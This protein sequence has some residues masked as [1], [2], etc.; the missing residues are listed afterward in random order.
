MKNFC[1]LHTH[2]VFSD[3]TYTPTELVRAASKLGL[4][5]IALT[6]HNTIAGLPEFLKA[7]EELGMEAVP[8]VEFSTEYEGLDVHI[9]GLF[10]EPDDYREVSELLEEGCRQKEQS[11]IALVN[12]LN[13]DGYVLNYDAIKAQSPKGQINR[14]HIAAALTEKGYTCSIKDAFDTLLSPKRGYYNPPRR[15]DVFEIIRFIKSLGAVAVLA[16]PLLTM[17][18]SMLRRFLPEARKHG[19]DAME[20]IYSTY[21]AETTAMAVKIASGFGLLQSGGSDFHGGRKPDTM[22][23]SGR[24]ELRVPLRIYERLKTKKK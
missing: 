3:G 18:E 14:A 11:N 15:P 16:H 2:S 9:L 1:D 23:G 5:A 20:T 19:L 17:D 8:G 6:D 10:I 4:G 7:A 22:L 13:A 21:D 24:G 12:A